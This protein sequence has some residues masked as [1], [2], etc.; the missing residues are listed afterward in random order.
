MFS[1]P[2][3]PGAATHESCRKDDQIG[4]QC[5]LHTRLFF[6]L[7]RIGDEI[8]VVV[9]SYG[10]RVVHCA[11]D[12]PSVL[13]NDFEGLVNRLNK[14]SERRTNPRRLLQISSAAWRIH[15]DQRLCA[16]SGRRTFAICLRP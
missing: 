13:I 15:K 7:S 14:T 2:V 9:E 3:Y 1:I 11:D 4:K 10:H 6:E 5:C 8:A 16:T 12:L